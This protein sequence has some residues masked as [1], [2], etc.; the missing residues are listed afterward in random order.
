MVSDNLS[1]SFTTKS[2][3][4]GIALTAHGGDRKSDQVPNSGTCSFIEAT[5][6]STGKS[7][8]TVSQANARAKALGDD[9]DAIAGTSLDNGVELDALAKMA[10][11][12]RRPPTRLSLRWPVCDF[13]MVLTVDLSTCGRA[14]K[15]I[16]RVHSSRDRKLALPLSKLKQRDAR[17]GDVFDRCG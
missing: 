17:R 16:S 15:S 3:L 12:E 5:A 10:K 4:P 6:K 9:L 13:P 8:S 7:R 11:E 1:E 2:D 14:A